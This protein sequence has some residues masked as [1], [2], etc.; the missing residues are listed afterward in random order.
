MGEGEYGTERGRECKKILTRT[1]ALA[2]K[3]ALGGQ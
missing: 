1:K 2:W 3:R